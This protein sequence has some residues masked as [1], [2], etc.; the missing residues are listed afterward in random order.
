MSDGGMFSERT[1]QQESYN[2]ND[3]TLEYGVPSERMNNM[4]SQQKMMPAAEVFAPKMPGSRDI[5]KNSI[6]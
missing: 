3:D 4:T 1:H 2:K 6:V 5:E